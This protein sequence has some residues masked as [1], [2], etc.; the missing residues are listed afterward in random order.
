VKEPEDEGG[1]NIGVLGIGGGKGCVIKNG[2]CYWVK[3][4]RT[5]LWWRWV[6][7]H[8]TWVKVAKPAKTG[9]IPFSDAE[10][11]FCD[12]GVELF[13]FGCNKCSIHD[14]VKGLCSTKSH[15]NDMASL[16]VLAGIHVAQIV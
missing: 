11:M 5:W 14:F 2:V 13:K 7:S 6:C 15:Y 12:I 4:W 16:S 8:Q 1:A 3:N 10:F 9:D